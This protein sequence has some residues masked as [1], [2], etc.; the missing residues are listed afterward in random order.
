[1]VGRMGCHTTPGI[2]VTEYVF[3]QLP[4]IHEHF[5][6]PRPIHVE[7]AAAYDPGSEQQ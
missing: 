3:V 6:P 2:R 4:E 7:I 5:D 1:M